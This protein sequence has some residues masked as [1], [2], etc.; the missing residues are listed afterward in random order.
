MTEKQEKIYRAALKLFAEQGYSGTSTS[1]IAKDAG[2]SEGLIFR[3]FGNKEG[4]LKVILGEAMEELKKS[5]VGV[6]MANEPKEV[7]RKAIELPFNIPHEQYK[8]WKLI[9]SLKWQAEH[10]ES[11]EHEPLQLI[12][13]NAFEQLG[14][15]DPDAELEFYMTLL[16]G[17]ASTL[18]LHPPKDPQRLLKTA[19]SK[20]NL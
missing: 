1:K 8:M 12:L 7:L 20:Y 18:L 3:H 17:M 5:A 19:L 4:L 15:E 2:V 13:R 6:L 16:D 10:Y 11:Q 9:Y 14:Y